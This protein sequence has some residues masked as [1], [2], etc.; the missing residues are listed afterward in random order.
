MPAE[1]LPEIRHVGDIAI[2]MLRQALDALR[3]ARSAAAA[4]DCARGRRDRRGI[5]RH[6]AAADHLHDGGSAHHLDGARD[7]VDRQGDRAHRRPC[8]EH[9]RAGDLHRQGHRRAP[10]LRS[11]RSSA[12]RWAETGHAR[13]HEQRYSGGRRR[14][15]D[16]GAD[17]GQPRARRTPRAARAQRGRGRRDDPRGSPRPDRARL[18]AARILPAR[19]WR[20]GCAPMRAA[21]TSR[22]SC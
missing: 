12:R 3:A 10:H 7:R 13:W 15:C 18:D 9:G 11:R 17:R 6:R 22:S 16:P 20:A 5:P 8:E 14:A 1:R 2:G 4:R 19:R 21:R